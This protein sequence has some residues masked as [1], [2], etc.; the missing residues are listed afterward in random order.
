MLLIRCPYCHETLPEAEFTY[1][2]Q[3]H[4]VRAADPHLRVMNSGKNSCSSAKTLGVRI[5]SAGGTC[6]AAA[7]SSMRC[8]TR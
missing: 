3:A 5:S 1:A 8:A 6:M 4:V 2:G 7:A